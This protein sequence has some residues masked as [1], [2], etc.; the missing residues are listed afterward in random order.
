[1][2]DNDCR[3]YL[4]L[5]AV[6]Q[7]ALGLMLFLVAFYAA[8][9]TLETAVGP[10]LI[11]VAIVIFII[12]WSGQV[13]GHHVEDTRPSF[14]K[15]IQFLFIGPLW[16]LSHLYDKLDIQLADATHVDQLT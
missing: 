2:R 1:M 14:I 13:I 5:G 6:R 7:L 11:R 10:N 8:A 9:V 12:G 16:E 4:L 15:D 3:F